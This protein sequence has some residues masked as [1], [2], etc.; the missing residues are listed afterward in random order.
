MKSSVYPDATEDEIIEFLIDSARSGD[1]DDGRDVEQVLDDNAQFINCTNSRGHSMLHYAA[2]NGNINFL[3]LLLSDKY[4]DT[5]NRNIQNLE[6]NTALHWAAMNNHKEAIITL[7]NA[8]CD[9]NIKNSMGNTPLGEIQDRD[10]EDVET[11]LVE[12][13]KG[14]DEYIQQCQEES[15][16][17]DDN[18]SSTDSDDSS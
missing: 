14:L 13:D 17:A 3:N 16:N 9:C 18:E 10:F 1:A 11:L 15:P 8:G 4:S 12:K 5:L 7:L 2:A 6:G